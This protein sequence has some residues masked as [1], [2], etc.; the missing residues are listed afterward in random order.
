M[1]Y[2]VCLIK[3]NIMFFCFKLIRFRGIWFEIYFMKK[4]SKC[5]INMVVFFKLN[6][7]YWDIKEKIFD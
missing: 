6:Y 1:C 5:M 3:Y 4:V 7:F 2:G